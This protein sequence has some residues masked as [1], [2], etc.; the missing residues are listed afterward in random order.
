[1]KIARL[2]STAKKFIA[3]APIPIKQ[4]TGTNFVDEIGSGAKAVEDQ[5]KAALDGINT[6]L[7]KNS[8]SLENWVSSANIAFE[9]YQNSLVDFSGVV[10]SALSG[11]GQ[12]LGNAISGS[13]T[14]GD[15]LLK[16]LGGVL[17]QLGG[18]L[19]TAGLGVEAFKESLKSLNGYVAV[20][21]GVALVALGS[22]ISGSIKGLGSNPTG[23]GG[24]SSRSSSSNN[25]IGG[26]RNQG[27]EIQLGGEWTIKGDDLVYIFNRQN[28]LNGRTRG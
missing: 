20:A 8:E 28:Q 21:A 4:K 23:G 19:I 14:L 3:D 7:I 27:L 12:A 18:M 25:N 10:H 11:I 24:S 26:L 9:N 5:L 13:E 22:A 16:V 15:G 6:G 2:S 1:L 17:T